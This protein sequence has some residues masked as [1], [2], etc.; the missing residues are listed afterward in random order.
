MVFKEKRS[1][2]FLHGHY[3]GGQAPREVARKYPRM[4]KCLEV[5]LF[6]IAKPSSSTQSAGWRGHG[7]P[8]RFFQK[9]Q[10]IVLM[11]TGH[12]SKFNLCVRVFRSLTEQKNSHRR[13]KQ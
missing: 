10:L 5:R 13:E 1:C 8:D 12:L 3:K 4:V 9:G 2:K 6:P 11:G 7:G